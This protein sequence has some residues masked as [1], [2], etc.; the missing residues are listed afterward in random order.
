[1]LWEL[2]HAEFEREFGEE[3]EIIVA[4]PGR[5]N[6]IGEHTD[7]NDG[8]VFPAAIDRYVV[9]AIG[10][11]KGP[12]RLY[13]T[14]I[15]KRTTFDVNQLKK[16][17]VYGWGG[18]VAGVAWAMQQE[19]AE[20]LPNLNALVMSDVPRGAGV[21]SSAAIE[22]AFGV[23][24]N[25][26]ARLDL[27]EAE[28]ALIGQFAEN[29]YVGLN[30][31]IMDQLASA[32]GRRDQAMFIDT[33]TLD[34]EYGPLPE[35]IQIVICNT[36][37]S[38][39]LASSKYNE[40]RSECEM[41]ASVLGVRSLREATM[42]SIERMKDKL[43]DTV[44][45]RAKHVITENQRC[46]DFVTALR[47]GDNEKVGELMRQSHISLRDDYEVSGPEL[48][49]MAE[50]CWKSSECIGARLTGAGF[51]GAC[52]AL[53]RSSGVSS[54]INQV[55]ARFRAQCR[56]EPQFFSCEAADGARV[57]WER[58]PEQGRK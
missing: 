36:G 5:V 4:A 25:T 16:G 21:S 43:G 15:D 3:P 6:L 34:I 57:V 7:Y 20:D 32:L 51:G 27:N 22:L 53:V 12:T 18:Y 30:C 37:A 39:S 41:A 44:Y 26:L 2:A 29:R 55:E 40:R 31:G 19:G 52:V 17:S 42:Q 24:W 11:T 45:R 48:N 38:R 47:A 8:F 54:F 23:A 13:S 49:A 14:T 50:E 28:L 35:G 56:T 46:L 9:A 33:K 1:M 58:E 10:L